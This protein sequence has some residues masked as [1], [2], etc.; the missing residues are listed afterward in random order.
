MNLRREFDKI[1]CSERAVSDCRA[2][3]IAMTGP[4]FTEISA[5]VAVLEQTSFA[6]AA[7]H[8]GLSP[9]RV[10]ELVR[11]LEQ[12]VGVRLV[13]RTTRS[14]APTEAGERLLAQLRHVLDDYQTALESL[15]DFGA[16]PAGVVRVIAPTIVTDFVLR[17]VIAPF[18]ARYPDVRL[19]ITTDGS[20]IDIV[21]RRFDAGIRLGDW[22][23]RDMI[24]VRVS[25]EIKL[26]VVAAPSYLARRARN[27]ARSRRP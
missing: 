16:K 27:P 13:E 9:P 8:L 14:V 2:M 17:P 26:V 25:D 5:F 20:M 23:E 21:A 7:R 15:S 4:S 10:S 1:E 11:N 3:G 12:R 19:E 6:N 18:L 22:L 24:A